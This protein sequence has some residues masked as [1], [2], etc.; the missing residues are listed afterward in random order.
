MTTAKALAIAAA[1]LFVTASPLAYAE[2]PAAAALERISQLSAADWNA[3]TDARIGLVKAALQL[4]PEQEKYWP[5]IEDAIRIRA[6]DKQARIATA[7]E[8]ASQLRDRSPIEV[9]SERN[10]V[11]FLRRRAEALTERAADLRRLADAWQPL[12]QTLDPEQ[13][14]RLAKT[15]I[16]V[17]REMRSH[18]EQRR[19]QSEDDDQD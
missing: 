5:P 6:K 11:D 10:P 17:F 14:Q 16:F 2:T 9:L 13:K 15:A 19:V 3:L 8:M 1:A 12:Y 7:S 18:A 4:T